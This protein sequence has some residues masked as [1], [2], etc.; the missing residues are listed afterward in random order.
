MDFSDGKLE[1][2]LGTMF[3]GKTTET[4]RRLKRYKIIGEKILVINSSVDTRS[5]KSELLTHDGCTFSCIKTSKLDYNLVGDNTVVSI[6]EAQ[7]FGND[8]VAVCSQLANS[9][10]R[11]IVAGLDMD[12]KGEPFG[13]MP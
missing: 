8:L 6:D 3:S 9:G 7:F 10:L 5:A 4:I 11:V 1:L 12:F 2:V 13:P